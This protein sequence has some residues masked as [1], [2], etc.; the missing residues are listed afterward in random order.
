[1]IGKCGSAMRGCIASVLVA[2]VVVGGSCALAQNTDYDEMADSPTMDVEGCGVFPAVRVLVDD[3]QVENRG[4]VRNGHTFLA[5]RE[6]LQR[7]GGDVRWDQATR[8]FYAGFPDRRRT[9]R[10][11]VG[12]RTIRIYHYDSASPHLAGAKTGTLRLDAAPFQCEGVVFAPVRS[13]VVAV[14]GSVSYDAASR[15]V[16]VRNPVARD[17]G[18][19]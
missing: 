15:T 2:L 13:A 9:V 12:S 17:E 8:S 14:G 4:F 6:A 18:T 1:M 3:Q 7:L 11:T 16:R 5:A 10:L 19:R